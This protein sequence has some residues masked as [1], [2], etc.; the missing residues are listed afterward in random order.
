MRCFSVHV[1]EL[2]VGVKSLSATLYDTHALQS[3]SVIHLL[4]EWMMMSVIA[5]EGDQPFDLLIVMY[6]IVAILIVIAVIIVI[7]LVWYY[8]RRVKTAAGEIN[9]IQ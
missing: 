7:V 6:I 8:R 3:R 9:Y 1:T 2:L 4:C 5:A